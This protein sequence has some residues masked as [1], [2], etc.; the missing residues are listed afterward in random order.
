[1]SLDKFQFLVFRTEIQAKI[2]LI[3]QKINKTA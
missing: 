2:F 1:M 3:Q